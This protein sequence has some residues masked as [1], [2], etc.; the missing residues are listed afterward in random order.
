MIKHIVM[1]QLK[2]HAEGA[3]KAT[4]AIKMK[5]LLDA[6]ANIVPGIIRLEVAIAKPGLE[7][8]YDVVLYSE[9]ASTAALDAYQ[10]HPQHL[11]LKPFVSAVRL[12]RQCMDYEVN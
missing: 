1:W 11:A 4:N 7:A 9:F 6:C 10:N 5:A 3:D 8:T 12:A 2:D